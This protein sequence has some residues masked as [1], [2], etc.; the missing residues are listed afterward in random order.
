M[1]SNHMRGIAMAAAGM[2]IISPD[3]LLIRLLDGV[4]PWEMVFFRTSLMG[5]ALGLFHIVRYRGRAVAVWRNI[6]RWGLVAGL[7]IGLSNILFVL[8]MLNTSVANTLMI[9]A[10]LPF[11]SAVAA[12]ALIGEKVAARTWVAIAVAFSGIV[13]IFYGSLGGGGL[14]GDIYAAMCAALM[15]LN[16]VALRKAGDRDMSPSLAIGGIFAACVVLPWV[17]FDSVSVGNMA[18][19]AIMGLVILPVSLGLFLGG[20]RYVAAA[21]VGL[22]ALIETVLGPIWAWVGVGEVPS[23]QTLVGGSVVLAAIAGNAALALL[24]NRRASQTTVR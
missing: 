11:F 13:F 3:G 6:G 2:L 14:T 20:A 10:A 8:A 19:L 9:V 21:E 23:W 1:S 22:L 18:I 17:T 16:L 24:R 15:A 7:L 4:G 5:L 12:W